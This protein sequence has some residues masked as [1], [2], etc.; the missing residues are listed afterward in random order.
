MKNFSYKLIMMLLLLTFG[1]S[2][3]F[4]QE[5]DT[6]T[7]TKTT[8]SFDRYLYLQAGIG[9]SQF[10][11]DLNENFLNNRTN[12]M[13]GFGLGYQ[14]SPVFGLRG[15]FNN[16]KVVST[17]KA[18]KERM[19]S[20][21]WDAQLDATVSLS[22]L[23]WGYKER[24]INIY[25]L[26]GLN[27]M[28]YSS[29]VLNT[30]G[31]DTY[32]DD[33]ILRRFGPDADVSFDA[34][35][36]AHN[37]IGVPVGLGANM[38][39]AEKWDL[40]LEYNHRITF[41]D[42][43]DVTEGNKNDQYASL[44][45]GVT[46]KF[47]GG[48]NLRSMEKNYDQVTMVATPNPLVNVGDTVCVNVKVT[49]PPKYFGKKAAMNFQP[50]IAYAGTSKKLKPVNF[51]GEKAEGNGIVINYKNG[52]SYTYVDCVPYEPG[53]NVSDL[54]VSP[55]VYSPKEPVSLNATPDQITGKYKLIE[56][57][58][59]KLAD[60][61][62]ITGTRVD[63][64][65]DLIIAEH[66]YE[67]ET[68]V[69]DD[70]TIY[71][72]VNLHNLNWNLPLNRN[73]QVKQ[74]IDELTNFIK[75]GYVIRDIDINAWASPEGEETFNQGLSERRAQTGKKQVLDM[76]KK[77]AKEKN[78]VINIPKP[79]D[80]LHFNTYANGEDWNGFMQAVEASN[81]ADKRI[82]MNVVNS[83]PDVNKREQE[84]R[85][86]AVV[87]REI[88]EEILP[89]LRRVVIKVNCYE[90]K[91]TDQQISTLATSSPS[92]LDNSELLY[93]ATLTD[94][95]N[96]K[97]RIY[98]NTTTQFPNDWKGFNNLAVV[99]MWNNK[100]GEAASSIQKA[101]SIEPNNGIVINNQGALES[102]KGNYKDA[103]ILYG[104]AK[105]L[106]MNVNYNLGIT[107]LA[108]SRYD[109]ALSL[110]SSKKCNTNV[111]LAQIMTNKY[112][113]AKATMKCAPESAHNYY[114]MAVAG[115]RTNDLKMITDNLTKAFS[116]DPTLKTQAAEDREFIKFFTNPDFMSLVK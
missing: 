107:Q 13:Y 116:I 10:Y 31:T 11:G 100:L 70:A 61:V 101:A 69:S 36:K 53:M 38:R 65:E 34:A 45:L 99:D 73:N 84:I 86:M 52:G 17:H 91:K 110:M 74:Q 54:V 77:M 88:E 97:E 46:Y 103:A 14:F 105:N 56:L 49:F 79:D 98:K 32:D 42:D 90:P 108:Q 83:Q 27:Y 21:I 9:G 44:M 16:G 76:F 85:N 75:K 50:E 78:A 37:A 67:K 62:I 95:L 43:L 24:L 66:G 26:A 4:A 92:E 58:Q 55:I 59:R 63:H 71:F 68:I 20:S 114:M 8:P 112:D 82:I 41:K 35:Q 40:F 5:Q 87:Y 22:N 113:E 33:I 29:M 89:P 15:S 18:L 72:Q 7:E 39:L 57:P 47:I 64:D 48:S 96:T 81:L 2:P 111:A 60:G 30:L 80:S 28:N 3:L 104:K 102:K 12:L 115:A 25:G 19:S 109:Q 51:Q 6:I 94:D 106:G 23:I 1:I 93:A